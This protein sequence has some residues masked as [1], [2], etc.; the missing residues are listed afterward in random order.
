MSQA[1]LQA[2]T[3]SYRP[4]VPAFNP[5]ISK[6][7]ILTQL[8]R[9]SIW[10]ASELTKKTTYPRAERCYL[11][12]RCW[13]GASWWWRPRNTTI[14]SS[15]IS[16]LTGSTMRIPLG[17]LE[18]TF[19]HQPATIIFALWWEFIHRPIFS[20]Q[21]QR[22]HWEI[23]S[24]IFLIVLIQENSGLTAQQSRRLEIKEVIFHK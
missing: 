21:R 1:K 19:T 6:F 16:S 4:P 11:G 8:R 22:K 2:F 13:S 20:C 7:A 14:T 15:L 24:W 3:F 12:W 18:E 23:L 10:E 5:A 9:S 17:Q